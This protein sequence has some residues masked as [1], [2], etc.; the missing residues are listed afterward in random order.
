MVLVAA[1]HLIVAAIQPTVM[2]MHD[3][4]AMALPILVVVV[5]MVVHITALADLVLL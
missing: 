5:A 3:M 1:K 2:A 4:A